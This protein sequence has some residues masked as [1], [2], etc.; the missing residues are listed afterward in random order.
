[1]PIYEYRCGD[2]G[3]TFQVLQR[4]GAGTEGLKCPEC[5]G[6]RIDRLLSCFASTSSGSSVSQAACSTGP[7]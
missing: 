5:G 4:I 7:T 6:G 3:H 2:C 1:M